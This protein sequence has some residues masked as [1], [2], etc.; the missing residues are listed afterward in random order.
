[1]IR[2]RGLREQIEVALN[3]DRPNVPRDTS[4]EQDQRSLDELSRR[5]YESAKPYSQHGSCLGLSQ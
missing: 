3:L 4:L 2:R 5:C 1:M